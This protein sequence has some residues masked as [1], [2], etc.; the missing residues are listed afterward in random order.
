[1]AETKVCSLVE[2]INLI[3]KGPA[4]MIGLEKEGTLRIGCSEDLLIVQSKGR[5]PQ[6]VKVLRP[7]EPS[8]LV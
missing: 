8:L 2:A 7:N 5:W 6:V 4:S 3:T 1:M